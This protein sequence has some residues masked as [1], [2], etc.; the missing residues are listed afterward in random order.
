MVNIGNMGISSTYRKNGFKD[1]EIESLPE[2]LKRE[3]LL[4]QRAQPLDQV[5]K[6]MMMKPSKWME[7]LKWN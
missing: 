1:M 2:E 7:V 3:A 5:Q 4:R 6:W